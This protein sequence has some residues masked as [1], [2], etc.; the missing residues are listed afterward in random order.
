MS[1]KPPLPSSPSS[2]DF[3][4]RLASSSL[5]IIGKLSD[6]HHPSL[7]MMIDFSV[8]L[9]MSGSDP[10]GASALPKQVLWCGFLH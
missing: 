6:I 9:F 3:L 2:I 10:L 5:D 7:A 8:R 1:Q 4:L